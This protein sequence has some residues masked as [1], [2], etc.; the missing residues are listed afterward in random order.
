MK[1][2][3]RTNERAMETRTTILNVE[4]N[5]APSQLMV[6]NELLLVENDAEKQKVIRLIGFGMYASMSATESNYVCSSVRFQFLLDSN[7]DGFVCSR[8]TGQFIFFG[9]FSSHLVFVYI[10]LFA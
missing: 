8:A 1:L 9:A 7:G 2:S 3:K 5:S 10:I 6:T 4:F